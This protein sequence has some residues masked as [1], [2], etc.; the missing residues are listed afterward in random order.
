MDIT[1]SGAY[2]IKDKKLPIVTMPVVR[3]L[4]SS[5]GWDLISYRLSDV[6]WNHTGPFSDPLT[7]FQRPFSDESVSSDEQHQR[8]SRIRQKRQNNGFKKRC[9]LRLVADYSFYS[10]YA[11][12]SA[13]EAIKIMVSSIEEVNRIYTHTEWKIAES[14]GWGFVIKQV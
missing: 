1:L 3:H 10:Q 6:N 9:S 5:S 2:G 14:L 11:R 8:F 4:P 12:S 13:S 7:L